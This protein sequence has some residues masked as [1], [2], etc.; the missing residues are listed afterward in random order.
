MLVEAGLVT[1]TRQGR[2]VINTVDFDRMNGLI[3]FLSE[4]CCTGFATKTSNTA[5]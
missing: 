1:Q 5:A 3:G 2:E 4:E